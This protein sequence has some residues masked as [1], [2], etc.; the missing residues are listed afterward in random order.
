MFAGYDLAARSVAADEVGGDFYDF[1]DFGSDMLGVSIGDASGHGLPAALLVRDVV[2]GLRMGI[3][4]E[5]KVAHVFEKLNRVIHRSRLSSRFVS[6]FYGELERGR[7]PRLR[8]RG[9]PAAHPLLP[10]A[11][12]RDSP[13]R[14]SCASAGP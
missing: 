6:V 10:G 14:W 12:A 2:T 13:P 8:E 7:E 1:E 11:A 5:L 9:P 3:E 4:K